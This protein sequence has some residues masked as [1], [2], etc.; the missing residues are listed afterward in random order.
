MRK[1]GEN[2]TFRLPTPLYYFFLF[3]LILKNGRLRGESIQ[4]LTSQ[5]VLAMAKLK[6]NELESAIIL[7]KEKERTYRT[8]Q[9]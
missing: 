7:K 2:S 6:H 1:V 3:F 5:I 9:F 8:C 4:M